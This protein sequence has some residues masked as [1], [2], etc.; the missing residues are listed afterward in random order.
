M[1]LNITVIL[2]Y[3]NITK[4]SVITFW[5]LGRKSA[6]NWDQWFAFVFFN[7]DGALHPISHWGKNVGPHWY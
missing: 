3:I 4:G 6:L 1:I 7:K 2:K 5:L